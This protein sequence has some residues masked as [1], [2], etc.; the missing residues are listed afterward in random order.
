MKERDIQER[1]ADAIRACLGEVPFIKVKRVRENQQQGSVEAD[2]LLDLKIKDGPSRQIVVEAKANGQ[3][4]LAR[5]AINQLLRYRSKFPEAYGVF[6]APY[7][8]PESAEIC[9]KEG[10][11]YLDL[12]G[13]CRLSFGQVFIRREGIRNPFAQK[14]DLRSLYAPKSTRVLRVLLMRTSEWWKTQALADEAGVSLGQV[15]NIKKRLRDREWVAEGDAGFRLTNPQRLLT[16]WAENY[17]YRKNTVRD[18][19]SMKG[20]DE[21]EEALAG[22]CRD[23]DI[24]YAFTGFSAARRVAPTV[25]GQRAVAYVSTISEVLLER[26]GLKEVSSGANVSLMLPYDEGVYYMARESNS[27]RVVCPVQLYLDL[28]GYKGRGEEAAEA[29]WKQE[30][31]RLW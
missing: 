3:P 6:M 16:E 5:E 29:V 22:V 17:T 26:A 4:R 8:S 7:I 11:G 21:V 24:Q 23:L 1:A 18:F 28:K 27:L 25:R 13:N 2:F 20:T 19:Y 14:R 15:A 31:S 12:A 10:V 9:A 30:L